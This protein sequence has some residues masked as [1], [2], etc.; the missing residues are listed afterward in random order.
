[1]S[2]QAIITRRLLKKAGIWNKPLNEIR[3]TMASIKGSGMP[4]GIVVSTMSLGGVSCEVFRHTGGAPR[5]A[6]LYFH[7]GGFCLGIYDANRSFAAGLAQLLDADIYMPDYR[8]A[9]EHPYPA[10]LEDAQAVLQALSDCGRLVVMGDSSGCALALSALQ[11]QNVMPLSLVMMTP[12]LDLTDGQAR[13]SSSVRKDPFNLEDPLK[14]T[15]HYTAGNNPSTPALS[16]IYG[17][18]KS[19]PPVLVHAAQFDAFLSDAVRFKERAEEAGAN[20]TLK[21]WPKMWHIFH[22]QSPFVP[23]ATSALNEIKAFIRKF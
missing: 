6:V 16:P 4:A 14:L 22:M 23:E 1:M 3:Q 5:P 7:G 13:I 8:L 9:P 18:L 17:S 10:A 21:I 12:V 20:V 19:L 2:T 15:R 11:G